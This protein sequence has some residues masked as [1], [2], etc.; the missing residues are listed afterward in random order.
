MEDGDSEPE[1]LAIIGM[2]FNLEVSMTRIRLRVPDGTLN[3]CQLGLL[4]HARHAVKQFLSGRRRIVVISKRLIEGTAIKAE[5]HLG[6][7]G[8]RRKEHRRVDSR[9]VV[10]LDETMRQHILDSTLQLRTQGLW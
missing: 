8:F 1:V 5:T 4:A 10:R 3:A 9:A 6:G 2:N 7:P